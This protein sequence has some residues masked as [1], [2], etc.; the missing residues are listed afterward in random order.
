MGLTFGSHRMWNRPM[1]L[2]VHWVSGVLKHWQ[3]TLPPSSGEIQDVIM[4]L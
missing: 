2:H 3:G 4:D 1:F